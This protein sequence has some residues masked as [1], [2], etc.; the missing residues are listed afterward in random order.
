MLEDR[1]NA[2]RKMIFHAK[3]G[4]VA[5]R[6]ERL[7]NLADILSRYI[8]GCD[9]NLARRAARL[10]KADLTTEMVGE[11]PGLQGIMGRHYA[12]DQ[13]ENPAVA[14]AIAQHYLP[15]G[16]DD[17]CPTAP[18]AVAVAL[19]EKLDT[20]VGFWLIDEKPTGS[21]DPFALRRAALGVIRLVLENGVRLPLIHVIAQAAGL[22]GK[23]RKVSTEPRDL[24]GIASD[25]VSF[26]ADRLR[27][28]LKDKDVS[29]GHI[30][31]LFALGD[32]DDLVRLVTRVYA[33]RDFLVSED[34]ANLLTTYRRA[35]NILRAEEK[36]DG[37][38][39]E[40]KPDA[41]IFSQSEEKALADSLE[42]A[43]VTAKD[44]AESEN[45]Q[46]AMAAV[47]NL[48]A[49][50]DAFFDAV[51]VNAG[52]AA[53]RENRLVLLSRIRGVMGQLADFSQIEG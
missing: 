27:V 47:A 3:L 24:A 7:A 41:G 13:N 21:K 31:A 9:G 19:A 15:A 33:L 44:A 50:V 42:N 53:V 39:Y 52:D 4:T 1:L 35:A 46:A 32:E 37:R 30:Q 18:T 10:A 28:H 5:E 20:L 23:Q 48:R 12:L 40:G 26:F 6:A 34:G 29:Q 38:A 22:Y 8:P 45:Y 16:P 43:A 2:L 49:P 11:F 51:T 14:D 36:K 17:S 25:L